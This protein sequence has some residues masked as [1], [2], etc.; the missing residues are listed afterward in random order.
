MKLEILLLYN[1][2]LI[3]LLKLASNSIPLVVTDPP[4]GISVKN[5]ITRKETTDINMDFGEWDWFKTEEDFVNF[6][7]KWF[8][9]CVRVLHEDGWMYIFFSNRH[10]WILYELIRK[11][12]LVIRASF[13]W[14]KSNPAPSYRK[15][16]WRS[17]TEP[18]LVL[19]KK[20]V[21]IPNFL[22]QWEMNNYKET[23]CRCNYGVSGHPT[24]KPIELIELFVRTSSNEGDTV[25]D[26]FMG[27]GTTGMACLQLNRK[28][29]GIENSEKW[30]NIAKERLTN[31]QRYVEAI[32]GDSLLL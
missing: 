16:N 28:F 1:D 32:Q 12:K 3:E 31:Y 19:T 11:F 13:T 17:A 7:R 10:M 27:S 24:E 18:I 8:T 6:T 21:R 2:C 25:L 5:K 22:T 15:F 29:I 9:E 23:S 30:Y 20:H 26:P 14:I 4:Y